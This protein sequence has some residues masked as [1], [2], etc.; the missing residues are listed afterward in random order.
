MQYRRTLDEVLR[1]CERR[2]LGISTCELLREAYL[3]QV[4]SGIY[5]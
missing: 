5:S 4:E 1:K 2:T 3:F